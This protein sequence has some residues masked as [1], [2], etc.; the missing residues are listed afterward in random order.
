MTIGPGGLGGLGGRGGCGGLGG[1]GGFG[2]CGALGG[3]G[4]RNAFAIRVRL[5]STAVGILDVNDIPFSS[6]ITLALSTR[7]PCSPTLQLETGYCVVVVSAVLR[8]SVA[9]A[10]CRQR[11]L[12]SHTVRFSG[13]SAPFCRVP[14]YCSYVT[15]WFARFALYRES[16]TD[17]CRLHF[18][19]LE[20]RRQMITRQVR[21]FSPLISYR[22][23]DN[24]SLHDIVSFR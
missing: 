12:P 3:L 23:Y 10:V 8:Q 20:R 19:A 7:L 4:T 22:L 16:H 17:T 9:A 5:L 21:R 24:I 6:F 1:K 15:I 13:L 18:F 14:L 2:G 11:T